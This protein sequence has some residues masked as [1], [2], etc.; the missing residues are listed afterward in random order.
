MHK[1]CAVAIVVVVVVVVFIQRTLVSHVKCDCVR[2]S[3]ER[4][5]AP[6]T[7][8]NYIL[9]VVESVAGA[10]RV[11]LGALWMLLPNRRT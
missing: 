9:L 6:F 5:G 11:K 8:S 10:F 2:V 7:Q 3:A 4:F 1:L